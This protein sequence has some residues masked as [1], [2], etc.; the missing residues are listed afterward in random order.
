MFDF[1]IDNCKTCPFE[2]GADARSWVLE[3][4]PERYTCGINLSLKSESDPNG[5]FN[6]KGYDDKIHDHCPLKVRNEA[7]LVKYKVKYC[8][9][10]EKSEIGDSLEDDIFE[11]ECPYSGNSFD[12]PEEGDNAG[13]PEPYKV[14]GFSRK[15][16]ISDDMMKVFPQTI[17]SDCPARF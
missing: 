13:I 5:I 9:V 4:N 15:R 6:V 2:I 10:T 11:G 3:F 12:M 14:C 17:H 1:K 8:C 16:G 7:T